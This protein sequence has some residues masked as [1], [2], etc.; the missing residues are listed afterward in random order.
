MPCT[1]HD[2]SCPILISIFGMKVVSISLIRNYVSETH[3]LHLIVTNTIQLGH[4]Y[5]LVAFTM[6]GSGRFIFNQIGDK[7]IAYR[8]QYDMALFFKYCFSVSKR[9]K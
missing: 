5:I 9:S 7:C 4:T 2:L 8:Y 3:H 1:M 6:G